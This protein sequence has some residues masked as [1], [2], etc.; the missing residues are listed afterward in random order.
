MWHWIYVFSSEEQGHLIPQ[1]QV[2]KKHFSAQ[3]R[4]EAASG[5]R[6]GGWGLHRNTLEYRSP[7][8][9]HVH[10]GQFG[11]KMKL[12]LHAHYSAPKF[13]RGISDGTQLAWLD[14]TVMRRAISVTTALEKLHETAASPGLSMTVCATIPLPRSSSPAADAATP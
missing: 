3:R 4:S 10:S 9:G 6:A 14:E 8:S 1:R 2:L 7:P 5:G 13:F 12:I 11:S